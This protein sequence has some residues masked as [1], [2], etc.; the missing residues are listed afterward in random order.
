MG[1]FSFVLKTIAGIIG[2]DDVGD[3]FDDIDDDIDD[4]IDVDTDDD[5]DDVDDDIDD[6]TEEINGF[7]E[8]DGIDVAEAEEEE[9]PVTLDMDFPKSNSI[10]FTGL[11]DRGMERSDAYRSWVDGVNPLEIMPDDIGEVA[12]HIAEEFSQ[13]IPEI[14]HDWFSGGFATV[15]SGSG[16]IYY[17]GVSIIKDS[18][19]GY[20]AGNIVGSIAHEMGHNIVDRVFSDGGISRLEHEIGADY[21]EGVV[22]GMTDV[23]P[24]EK[25]KWLRINNSASDDY[26]SADGR[27]DVIEEGIEWGKNLRHAKMNDPEFSVDAGE[28][29]V[30]FDRLKNV[31]EKYT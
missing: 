2:G 25:F 6:D 1:I 5:I 4:E 23:D 3:D 31:M 22:F 17:D 9:P 13:A 24:T 30:L 12:S 18:L 26:L 19:S 7:G 10:S 21:M 27:I 28:Q 8:V 11:L 14:K 15:T 16:T 20:G 29:T